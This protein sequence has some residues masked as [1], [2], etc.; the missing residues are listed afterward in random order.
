MKTIGF[1]DYYLSEW[2]ANNYPNWI[3]SVCEKTSKDFVVKYAWAE[4][5]ISPVDGRSTDDWCNTFGVEKCDTI[6]EVCQK[7]DY[8]IVLAPSNPEK[9]L[10]YVK[11]VF[12][13][14]KNTYVDKTF[15]PDFATAKEMFDI[16]NENGTKFFSS[17]ALR[18][19][20]ELN[21]LIDS[22]NVV[23]LV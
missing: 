16:A 4:K 11:E 6:A 2:H 13:Y 9:H 17:S 15:A 19:A 10:A 22:K 12:K 20:D 18:Y 14:K 1:I 7:A 3:K 8:I 23:V 21:D 5:D